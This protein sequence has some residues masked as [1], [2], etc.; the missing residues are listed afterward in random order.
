MHIA[1]RIMLI[2]SFNAFNALIKQNSHAFLT[3]YST[4]V[5]LI[6]SFV[7]GLDLLRRLKYGHR[8]ILKYA[9]SNYVHSQEVHLNY[10]NL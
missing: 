8:I 5:A 1:L 10:D 4:K 2:I 9:L 6:N 7:R 3:F